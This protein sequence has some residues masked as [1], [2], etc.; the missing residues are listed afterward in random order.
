MDD[1]V[2]APYDPRWPQLFETAVASVA[3]ALNQ[4]QVIRIDHIGSTAVPG[5]AAKPIIDLLVMVQSLAEARQGAIAPLQSLGY[6]YWADNPNPERLFF[7]KGLPPNGPR[8]HHVH[9]TESAA[10]VQRHLLFRDYLRTHPE[11]ARCYA[12]LKSC[13]AQQFACDRE[14]YTSGKA[15]YIQ[16]VVEQAKL[17]KAGSEYPG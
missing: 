16:T 8:T 4:I 5:L 10:V 3:A 13:L 11:E 12:Q 2:I 17:E 15:A 7:V 6:A 9:I 1:I 14:A